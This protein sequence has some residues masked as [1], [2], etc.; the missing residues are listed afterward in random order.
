MIIIIP[1]PMISPT[2][3]P[4]V[5]STP[6]ATST[7]A[8]TPDTTP[9]TTPDTTPGTG[10]VSVMTAMIDDL[11]EE[12]LVDQDGRALYIFDNDEEGQ[13][14]C[15]ENCAGIWPPFEVDSGSEVTAGQGVTAEFDT[16]TRDDG[17]TQAT[18]NG[19]PLYYYTGDSGTNEANGQGIND[20]W[21]VVDADGEKV[22]TTP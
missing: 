3:V 9:G 7:P 22:T 2:I 8:T 4:D 20:V 14:N 6:D 1:G 16:I 17:T 15:D 21:W 10:D 5:T 19:M 12:I 11:D 13:S 18:V